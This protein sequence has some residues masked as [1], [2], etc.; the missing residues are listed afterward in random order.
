M[1]DEIEAR[2]ARLSPAARE[3]F[4]EVM[5]RGEEFGFRAPP[6][7][8]LDN[9][10]LSRIKGL[11]VDERR[12]FFRV[13]GSVARQGREEAIRLQADAIRFEGF[14]KLI[15]RAQELDRQAGRPINED[16]TL[17]EAIPKL[18]AAG[19]LDALEREYLESVKDEIVWVP[20]EE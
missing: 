5:R 18:E 12:E 17:K 9:E 7:E 8:V 2:I 15:E 16:M 4:W 1:D 13:F 20:R 11:P 14:A 3:L 19:K 6:L 10:L